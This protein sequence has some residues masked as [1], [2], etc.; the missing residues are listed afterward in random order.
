MKLGK[1]GAVSQGEAG[2]EF[3]QS[4][5]STRWQGPDTRAVL[6]T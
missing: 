5:T 6:K 1:S 2:G 3:R 4:M